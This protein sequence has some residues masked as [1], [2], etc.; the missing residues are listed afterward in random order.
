[1]GHI[2]LS[3]WLEISL[4]ILKRL[5]KRKK[6]LKSVEITIWTFTNCRECWL[7]YIVNKKWDY[8]KQFTFCTYEHRNSDSIIINWKEWHISHNWD[9]PYISDNKW[10]C[11]WDAYPWEYDKA[12]DILIN[13]INKYFN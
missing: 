10:E 12:T 2:K 13:E 1:M 3:N 11:L 9:L 4:E 7:T 8:S 5:K 6:E